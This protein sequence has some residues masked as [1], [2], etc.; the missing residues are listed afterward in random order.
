MRN[1]VTGESYLLLDRPEDAPPPISLGFTP[2]R[3]YVPSMPTMLSKVEDR[4]PEASGAR[5]SDLTDP[6][7]DCR[8][9]SRYSRPDRPI[10][11]QHRKNSSGERDPGAE[12]RFAEIPHDNKH[13]AGADGADHVRIE[14]AD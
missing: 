6:Q 7:G 9:G 12:R 1:P 3:A 5:S 13:A 11:H 8:Q 14:Q 10:F 4:L 2:D